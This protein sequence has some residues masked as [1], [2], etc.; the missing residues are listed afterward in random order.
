[1]AGGL[2]GTGATITLGTTAVS[3]EATDVYDF[4]TNPAV[5]DYQELRVGVGYEDGF[6]FL[7]GNGETAC[8]AIDEPAGTSVFVGTA[9][10]PVAA[11]FDLATLAACQ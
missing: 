10:T 4:T 8:V 1:M 9:G 3:L 2:E 5:I 11:P 7:L 6:D